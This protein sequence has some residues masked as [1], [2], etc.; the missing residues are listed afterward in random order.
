MNVLVEVNSAIDWKKRMRAGVNA[1]MMW[2]VVL[3]LLG[4]SVKP[5]YQSGTIMAVKTHQ[6]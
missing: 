6:G 5:A 2:M 1:L 3:P 4:Q